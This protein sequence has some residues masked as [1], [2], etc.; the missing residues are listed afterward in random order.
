MYQ[1]KC[2][3]STKKEKSGLKYRNTCF[4]VKGP[5]N[6]FLG[7]VTHFKH[8]LLG[9]GLVFYKHIIADS[10]IRSSGAELK[11]SVGFQ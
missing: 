5:Q 4:R 8:I 7:T 10:W 2:G 11:A 6:V 1:S 3:N 9:I